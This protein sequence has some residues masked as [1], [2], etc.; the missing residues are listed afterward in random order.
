MTLIVAFGNREC[1]YQ[2]SDSLT[3]SNGKPIDHAY[4]KCFVHQIQSVSALIG[5]TGLAETANSKRIFK[6]KDWLAEELFRLPEQKHFHEYCHS[7]A[8]LA[9][10]KFK[11]E[12]L[13]TRHLPRDRRL[14]ILITAYQS[15]ENPAALVTAIVTN[16]Q[17]E[18]G[19]SDD[20][21]RG[22]FDFGTWSEK[23]A[24]QGKLTQFGSNV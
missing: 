5:F 12:P 9:T 24:S 3:S 8:A 6:T 20:D 14:T 13:I 19:T 7:I 18:D 11:T 16:Y 21:A 23:K 1:I 4:N 10:D 2:M 15:A 22:E 17:N